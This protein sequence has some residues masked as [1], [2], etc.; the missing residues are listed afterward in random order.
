[1]PPLLFAL[2]QPT[3]ACLTDSRADFVR[4]CIS[5]FSLRPSLTSRFAPLSLIAETSLTV[6]S[7]HSLTR[8]DGHTREK[9]LYLYVCPFTRGARLIFISMTSMASTAGH[10]VSSVEFPMLPHTF[11]Y[12]HRPLLCRCGSAAHGVRSK[13]P[14]WL[15]TYRPKFVFHTPR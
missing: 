1:M 10:F 3:T 13:Q 2:M 5:H 15:R 12:G 9:R 14:P 4:G 6:A 11:S 7:V 8:T